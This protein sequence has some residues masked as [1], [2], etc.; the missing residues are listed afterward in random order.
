MAIK[1]KQN[2]ILNYELKINDEIVD[3]NFDKEPIEFV[4][5]EGQLIEGLESGIK[6]MN[7]GDSKILKIPASQAYGEYDEKL[8]ETIDIKDFEGI[9]LQIGMVLEA[10]N[11][12]DELIKA[13]VTD[14]T[15]E[16]VTVDYNHPLAGCD[17]EFRVE[18][19]SI[20]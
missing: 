18:I 1:E 12:N 2:V 13:T 14:V 17:L 6:D 11:S 3:T 5:G 15:K 9:D 8:S 19:K 10:E 4:Y 7:E 16:N 20:I